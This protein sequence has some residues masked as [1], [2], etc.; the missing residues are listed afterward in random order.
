MQ[1]QPRFDN[2]IYAVAVGLC[3]LAYNRLRTVALCGINFKLDLK[4]GRTTR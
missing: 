1:Y 2:P 3:C 4:S